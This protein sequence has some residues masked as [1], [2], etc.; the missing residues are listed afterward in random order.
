MS[1]SIPKLVNPQKK[2][3]RNEY[4]LFMYLLSEKRHYNLFQMIYIILFRCLTD[5]RSK[6]SFV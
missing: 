4:S 1:D 5:V 6:L 3:D 2:D